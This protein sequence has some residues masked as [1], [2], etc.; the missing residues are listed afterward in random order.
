MPQT[1]DHLQQVAA[2]LKVL[3]HLNHTLPVAYDWQVTLCFYTAVHLVNAHLAQSNLQQ[4]SHYDTLQLINPHKSSVPVQFRLSEDAFDACR[5]LQSLSRRAR[6]LVNEK[7]GQLSTDTAAWTHAKHT[8]KAFRH[9][10]TLLDYFQTTHKMPPLTAALQHEGITK[11][12]FKVL[13]IV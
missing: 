4:R 13:T 10:D 7:D 12:A 9:L 2:N 3:E 6:Y 8:A 1:T 5:V 11:N